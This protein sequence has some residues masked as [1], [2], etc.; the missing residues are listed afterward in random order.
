MSLDT[1]PYSKNLEKHKQKK[2]SCLFQG[3]K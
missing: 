3:R 2:F 1:E